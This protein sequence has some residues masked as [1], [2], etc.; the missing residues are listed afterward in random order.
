MSMRR[1]SRDSLMA[2]GKMSATPEGCVRLQRA[3]KSGSVTFRL[4]I[5]K[6]GDRLDIIAGKAY[7]N[8]TLWWVIAAASNIGW[9]LQVPPGT[10]LRIPSR[11]DQVAMLVA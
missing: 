8:A 6:E 1:Y 3:I 4:Y 2:A 7:G 10:R 9:G 5:S 11:I